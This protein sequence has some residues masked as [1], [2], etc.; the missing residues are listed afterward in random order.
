MT[1]C[2]RPFIRSLLSTTSIATGWAAHAGTEANHAKSAVGAG[3][4]IE[5]AATVAG[6]SV[7]GLPD[8]AD[9]IG[10]GGSFE[11]RG[12]D[13]KTAKSSGAGLADTFRTVHTL[14]PLLGWVDPS[15]SSI[16]H[17]CAVVKREV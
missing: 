5:I 13:I 17:I 10:P 9:K 6:A 2:P 3:P 4:G 14:L 15:V 8:M 12:A 7:V 1:G 11:Q 16:L